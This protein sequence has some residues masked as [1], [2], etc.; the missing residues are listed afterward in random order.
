M[1]HVYVIYYLRWS[2][3]YCTIY[4]GI[5]RRKKDQVHFKIAPVNIFG[6]VRYMQIYSY[7]MYDYFILDVYSNVKNKQEMLAVMWYYSENVYMVRNRNIRL[8]EQKFKLKQNIFQL[9]K[10][11]FN[12][13]IVGYVRVMVFN[14]TF[15]NISV[16]S[17]RQNSVNYTK[18]FDASQTKSFQLPYIYYVSITILQTSKC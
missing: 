9:V 1:L 13:K 3:R 7:F 4:K 5:E 11:L 10:F 14:A 6:S 2:T 16:I 18:Y 12:V 17:W 8:W 15:N